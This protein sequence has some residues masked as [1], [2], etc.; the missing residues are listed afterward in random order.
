MSEDS[1]YRGYRLYRPDARSDADHVFKAVVDGALAENRVLKSD[2]Q[3]YAGLVEVDG[4]L[5]VLKVPR[6]RNR[7]IWQRLLSLFRIGTAV[8]QMES[9]LRLRQLG[10]RAPQPVCAGERRSLGM[11]V[12]SFL[13][14]EY[15]EGRM[16]MRDDAHLVTPELLRL[17]EMGYLR[18]DPHAKNY[19]IDDA[20]VVFIDATLSRPRLFR[21]LRLRRELIRFVSSSPMAVAYVPERITHSRAYRLAHVFTSVT[22]W[23]KHTR[24][25]LLARL[26][27][28]AGSRPRGER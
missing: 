20:G 16:A 13:V 9:M 3:T 6:A 10:L 26:K 11:L 2:G 15:A 5:Y 1:V 24:R 25:G 17:H 4:Q 23:W 21:T 7:R 12:D 19:L 14:Y 22:Q 27:E 28:R 8:R 18:N